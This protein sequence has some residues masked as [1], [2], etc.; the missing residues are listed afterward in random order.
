MKKIRLYKDKNTKADRY[1][2]RRAAKELKRLE[3]Q[4]D[5]LYQ[6]QEDSR[7]DKHMESCYQEWSLEEEE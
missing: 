1:R 6:E 5:R 7:A 3:A 4:F 2:D